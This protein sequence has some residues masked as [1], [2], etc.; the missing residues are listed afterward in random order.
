MKKLSIV[1]TGR[2]D[3]YGGD[4]KSRLERCVQSLYEQLKRFQISSEIIF[5]N[6]N[7]LSEP[8][9]DTFINWPKS[10]EIVTVKIITVPNEKHLSFVEE[11][12]IKPLPVIEY[13]GKNVGI[14]RSEGEYIL[15]MNPDILISNEIIKSFIS[16]IDE[17]HYY[18]AN[19]IDFEYDSNKKRLL[20]IHLKGREYPVRNYSS[21]E[22]I[23]LNIKDKIRNFYSRNTIH[24]E[25]LFN[26][27]SIP[28]IYDNAELFYHCK[29]SGDFMLMHRNHWHTLNA[30]PET[31]PI[32]LHIDSLFTIQTAMLPLK[33]YI[34]KY[35]IFHEEHERRFTANKK[36]EEERIAYDRYQAEAQKMLKI[37]KPIIYNNEHWGL[38]NE[39]LPISVIE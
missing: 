15:C 33:E 31:F 30:Y 17:K 37:K 14:R 11:Y 26:R 6:Y 10:T 34:Y 36:I 4:F 7:P 18:R 20:Q 12:Q 16:K 24:F 19:R 23:T 32:A 8:H 5:V 1:F 3:D 27:L 9:I 13:L 39:E 29:T 2:N 22:R 28:V 38:N 21:T 25:W 35:P